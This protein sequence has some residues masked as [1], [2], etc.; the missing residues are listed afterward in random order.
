MDILDFMI[1]NRRKAEETKNI[2][3]NNLEKEKNLLEKVRKQF[4]L[5]DLLINRRINKTDIIQC[6]QRLLNEQKYFLNILT[7]CRLKIDKNYNLFLLIK[8]FYKI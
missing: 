2:Y 5:T 6:C 7:K 3:K 1:N 8:M 4:H